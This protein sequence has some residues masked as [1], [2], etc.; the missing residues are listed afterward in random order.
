MLDLLALRAR[1][2]MCPDAPMTIRERPAPCVGVIAE[3]LDRN[4]VV[5]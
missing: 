3:A 4:Q 1:V 2:V 5:L